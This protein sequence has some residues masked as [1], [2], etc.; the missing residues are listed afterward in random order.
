[1]TIEA[2]LIF[3]CPSGARLVWLIQFLDYHEKTHRKLDWSVLF[4]LNDTNEL[5]R[6][7]N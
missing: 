2:F 1:M 6:I 4:R 5:P 7:P 3:C